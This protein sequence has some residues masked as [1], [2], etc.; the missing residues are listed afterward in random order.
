M[1]AFAEILFDL[2]ISEPRRRKP[3]WRTRCDTWGWSVSKFRLRKSFKLSDDIVMSLS[4][5][6]VWFWYQWWLTFDFCLVLSISRVMIDTWS[7]NR[8]AFNVGATLKSPILLEDFTKWM[9]MSF[10]LT[11][12]WLFYF[13]ISD[14]VASYQLFKSLGLIVQI[15]LNQFIQTC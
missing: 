12:Q 7:S 14:V 4:N 2:L 13:Y 1:L 8:Q 15:G 11:S 5:F 6:L 9:I 3:I 10:V